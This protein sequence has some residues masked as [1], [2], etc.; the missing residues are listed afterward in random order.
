MII[1]NI[2]GLKDLSKVFTQINDAILA[3]YSSISSGLANHIAAYSIVYLRESVEKN[4]GKWTGKFAGSIK[5]LPNDIRPGFARY[6][7]ITDSPY[8]MWLEYGRAAPIGLPYSDSGKKDYSKSKFKGYKM[9]DKGVSA[10]MGSNICDD[11]ITKAL[12]ESLNGKY[13]G[14]KVQNMERNVINI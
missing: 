5:V 10:V 6:D 14:S 12:V 4:K 7:I 3:S 8:F 1:I 13:K 11:I 2:I 9:F